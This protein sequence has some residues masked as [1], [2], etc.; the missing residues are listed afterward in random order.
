MNTILPYQVAPQTRNVL[1]GPTVRLIHPNHR[2]CEL[3]GEEMGQ[4]SSSGTQRHA[5]G[6]RSKRYHDGGRPPHEWWRDLGTS[7]RWRWPQDTCSSRL[8]RHRC[9][10]AA[11]SMR[12]L[13]HWPH[14]ARQDPQRKVRLTLRSASNPRTPV[15]RRIPGAQK[16][17]SRRPLAAQS[18]GTSQNAHNGAAFV[19]RPARRSGTWLHVSASSA[20]FPQPEAINTRARGGS[21]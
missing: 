8:A 16:Y 20:L 11:R 7:P 3:A 13:H 5:P 21:S 18:P 14:N 12:I 1:Q 2:A 10:R 17:R 9:A 4:K 15:E 19:R 6:R